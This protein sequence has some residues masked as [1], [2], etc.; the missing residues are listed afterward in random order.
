MKKQLT[1]LYFL[2][3]GFIGCAKSQNYKSLDNNTFNEKLKQTPNAQLIDVRTPE[4]FALG[5]L[6]NAIN[7]D[8]KNANFKTEIAKINKK[9][10]VFVY[11]QG[12][13]R[14]KKAAEI[15][16]ELGFN[17]IFELNKGYSNWTAKQ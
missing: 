7:I 9:Q 12:G 1:L 3:L 13:G 10:A 4:E 14:S 2:I 17:T 6:P 15:L 8:L 11:C 16:F 5:S